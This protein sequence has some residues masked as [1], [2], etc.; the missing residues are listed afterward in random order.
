MLETKIEELTKA[1]E[2]LTEVILAD[3]KADIPQ[4]QEMNE[5]VA[6]VAKEVEQ[7]AKPAETSTT[8]TDKNPDWVDDVPFVEFEE[9]KSQCL[10]YARNPKV[11]KFKVK[12]TLLSFGAA[13]ASEIDEDKRALVLETLKGLM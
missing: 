9:F 13:K 4:L 2:R 10:S 12:D 7:P 8:T 11:G 6:E 1:I 5:Q 3:V